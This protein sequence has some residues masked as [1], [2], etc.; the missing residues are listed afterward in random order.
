MVLKDAVCPVVRPL[1]GLDASRYG[2]ALRTGLYSR[3]AALPEPPCVRLG[4][5]VTIPRA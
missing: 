1:A 3:V 2:R 4:H 5:P